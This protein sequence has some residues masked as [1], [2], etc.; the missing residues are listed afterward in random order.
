MFN[1]LPKPFIVLFAIKTKIITYM[2][3]YEQKRLNVQQKPH[4]FINS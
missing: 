3:N 4:K 2:K 1:A